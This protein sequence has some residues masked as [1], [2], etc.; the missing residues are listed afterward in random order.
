VNFRLRSSKHSKNASGSWQLTIRPLGPSKGNR[1]SPLERSTISTTVP[2]GTTL[3]RVDREPRLI[4]GCLD[5]TFRRRKERSGPDNLQSV[6]MRLL[7]APF[8]LD[9]RRYLTEQ[10]RRTTIPLWESNRPDAASTTPTRSLAVAL[11]GTMFFLPPFLFR[12][13]RRDLGR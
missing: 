5:P 10:V 9:T 11:S 1:K 3:G 8:P 7:V 6:R 4:A 13:L 12:L 2:E